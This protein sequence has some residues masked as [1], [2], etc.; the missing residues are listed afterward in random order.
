MERSL[1]CLFLC[2]HLLTITAAPILS[3]KEDIAEIIHFSNKLLSK[4][5]LFKLLRVEDEDESYLQETSTGRK[6]LKFSIKETTCLTSDSYDLEKCDFKNDGEVMACVAD[7]ITDHQQKKITGQCMKK[8]STARREHAMERD[9]VVKAQK[10]FDLSV[11][12]EKSHNQE[13]LECIFTLLPKHSWTPPLS[14]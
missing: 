4:N 10:T 12:P 7:I 6:V 14:K 11:D 2:G 8:S 5:F 1:K 9:I 3:S 13:C